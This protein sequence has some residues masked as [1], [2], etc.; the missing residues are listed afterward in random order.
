MADRP[1]GLSPPSHFGGANPA[2]HGSPERE[3]E[4]GDTARGRGS[5]RLSSLMED[6]GGSDSANPH[7]NDTYYR[8][9]SK[10]VE[11]GKLLADE[12]MTRLGQTAAME[13]ERL[14][15]PT[16]RDSN[17]SYPDYQTGDHC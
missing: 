11:P 8:W 12:A 6:A 1:K 17:H 16:W 10:R 14:I 7:R 13:L 4:H 9:L 5:P 3:A 15:T 2:P